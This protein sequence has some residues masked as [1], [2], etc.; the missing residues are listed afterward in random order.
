MKLLRLAAT[1]LLCSCA[2][3]GCSR[4]AA[5]DLPGS[6]PAHARPPAATA[7]PAGPA[8][9]DCSGGLTGNE[10]GVARI[11]CGGAATI[12][13]RAGRADKEFHGGECHSAGDV[14]SA[15]AGVVIDATGSHGTYTGKPVDSVAVNNTDT[16][17]RGTIQV[18]LDG[19]NYYD[20]GEATMTLATG[21]K[22]AHIRGT[23]DRLSDAPG[24]RITVDVTC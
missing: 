5:S 3:S 7:D 1:A 16:P 19:K 9:G 11:T 20:L 2:L 10:P 15:A 13:V 14:W 22:S 21:G 8:G 18:M 12:H 24:A 6:P 17:G 4:P 23:S